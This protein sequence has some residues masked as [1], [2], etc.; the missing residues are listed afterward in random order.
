MGF[1]ASIDLSSLNG[2]NGF[3]ISGVDGF[4][5]SGRA[6]SNAGDVNG[7]GIDDIIIGARLADPNSIGGAEGASYV[8]FGSTEGFNAIFDL[9]DLNG[10]NGFQLSG[11]DANDRSGFSVSAAGDVNGDGIDDLLVGARLADPNSNSNAGETYVIFGRA[12]FTP[13]V[14]V[15]TANIDITPV[16]DAPTISGVPTDLQVLEDAASNV[17]L[18]GVTLI[19]VDADTLTLTLTIDAGT[20]SAPA[21]GSMVGSG[22]TATLVDGQTI[23]LVGTAADINTYLDTAS[24]IQYT[25]AQ[26][27]NGD[28]QATLSL[29]IDDGT[30]P[31][32]DG[33]DVNIDITPVNDAPIVSLPVSSSITVSSFAGAQSVAGFIGLATGPMDEISQTITSA[34]LTTNNDALFSGLPT[35]DIATGTVNFTPVSGADGTVLVTIN[36]IDDGGTANGGVDTNNLV[37]FTIILNPFNTIL[38][39][40]IIDDNLQGTP[41]P[42]FIFG[43]T[44]DDTLEGLGSDDTLNGSQGAD[45]LD[46]GDGFDT[47]DYSQSGSAVTVRLDLGTGS[48]APGSHADGDQLT[49]IEAI[50]GSNFD[51]LI[52]GQTTASSRLEGGLGDDT[53]IGGAGADTLD[54]GDDIDLVDYSGATDRVS[55]RLDGIAGFFGDALGDIISNIENIT[56]SAFD[57]ILVGS[58]DSNQIEAGDGNDV[59]FAIDGNDTVMGGAGNDTLN[60]QGGDDL[61]IGD[62]GDDM[63][64]GQSGNDT[65][66]GGPGADNLDGGDGID[67]VDYS[68]AT[69][70]VGARLDGIA[71]FI[72]A[73]GDT[74]MNIENLIGSAFNDTL[75]GSSDANQINGGAGNDAVFAQDGND[76]LMGGAGDDTL[77]GQAGDDVFLSDAGSDILFGGTGIDLADYSNATRGVGARLDGMAGFAGANGDITTDIENLT[78]SAFDD[79]LVGSMGDNQIDAGDGNDAVFALEGNDTIIGGIGDDTL[80][81]QS[82]DDVF[83]FADS[84]GDDVI[85]DFKA[86]GQADQIDFSANSLINSFADVMMNITDDGNGN[87][88]ITVGTDSITLTGILSTSLQAED[89]LF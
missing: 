8:V 75:V 22:V 51:D 70:R 27:V 59:V 58:D 46:G 24:N 32:V 35:V 52:V 73:D 43:D 78:G 17:D 31:T 88:I 12:N 7:D 80:N 30:A 4:D 19:D 72:A 87:A 29:A 13:T 48:G 41:D 64:F 76:T 63:L 45:S 79:I 74:A 9:S 82:G 54:G 62:A 20:F 23:T 10:N 60:G 21:D 39:N 15:A 42:D 11:I 84:F 57:D 65:L 1:G 61:V 26:D 69:D 16:N 55:A 25:G 67:V 28:N 3:I 6:V 18:S 68:S 86:A 40:P 83:V 36:A 5:Q 2:T 81:G 71:G 89:F 44:G 37:T 47:A 77:R 14:D 85:A 56:G 50:I 53:L 49:N 38:G 33:G 34:T 66:I